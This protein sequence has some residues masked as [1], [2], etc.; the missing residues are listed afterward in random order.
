MKKTITDFVNDEYKNYSKYVLYNRAIGSVIDGFKPVQRKIFYLIKDQKDFIKTASLAGN[1]ISKAGYNHGDTSAGAAASLMAQSFVGANN[2]PLLASKGS[3]GNRFINEP[4]ATR[5]TYV[6]AAKI[7]P[8]LYKDYDICP[9]NPD[10]ENPEPLYF[11][12]VIP[13]ILLN[14]IKG[15]AVGF[16][17]DIPAFNIYDLINESI[18]ILTKSSRKKIDPFWKDYKGSLIK[19][20]E[21]NLVQTG[22]F[23]KVGELK[24]HISEIPISYDREKYISHLNTLIDKNLITNFIDNSKEEWN[25]TISLPKKSKVW[26]DP[27]KYLKLYNN[28]NYNLTCIDENENLKIFDSPDEILE[29]FVNFR[30]QKFEQRRLKRIQE[31][32]DLINFNMDKIKFILAAMDYDFKNKTKDTIWGDFVKTFIPENLEKF[33]KMSISNINK[34]TILELKEKIKGYIEEKKYFENIT[35]EELY[36]KDLN[37]LK[38]FC[39]KEKI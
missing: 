13:T 39:E 8:Y 10:P 34:D 35:K 11:L 3:F 4:S 22:I 1:L 31:Y 19:D 24:I 26:E 18:S 23:K 29:Y 33:L 6:K 32:K 2:I 30:V 36:I 9:K 20:E 27:I 28:I 17:S 14:G 37:E 12:P 16:A 38:A 5:Y 21:G 25:I 15:I 7:L